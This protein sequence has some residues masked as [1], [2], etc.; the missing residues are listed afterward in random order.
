MALVKEERLRNMLESFKKVYIAYSG[1][2]DSSY[3]LAIALQV[4]G[5][6]GVVS[7]TFRSDLNPVGEVESAAKFARNIGAVQ[8]IV[9]VDLCSNEEFA[10]NSLERCYVCK[11]ILFNQLL[12]MAGEK[13]QCVVLDGSNAS[14]L[15]DFRPGMK[16]LNELSIRSPLLEC[17]L[18]KNDIR[19]LSRQHQ[20]P[21]WDR[22]S[23]ACLASRFPHGERITDIKLNR[24]AKAEQFLRRSGISGNLR[25]RSH[26]DLARVE[27]DREAIPFHIS[28]LIKNIKQLE[29]IGFRYVTLDLSGFK[30]GSMNLYSDQ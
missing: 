6:E 25:V 21:T 20:F 27:I 8:R 23:T 11:K 14:D 9:D 29:K 3:L 30:S 4:I 2:V 17:G 26:G 15:N 22:L 18:G 12:K 24:V 10:I 19:L 5:S 7:V 13:E 1:G 16:A 28:L